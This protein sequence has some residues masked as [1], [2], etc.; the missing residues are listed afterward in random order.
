MSDELY[1]EDGKIVEGAKSPEDIE[2]ELDKVKEEVKAEA[3]ENSKVLANEITTLQDTI[4][5]KEKELDKVGDKDLNFGKLRKQKEEAEKRLTDMKGDLESKI[6]GVEEKINNSKVDN[7]INKLANGDSELADK[8]KYHLNNFKPDEEQDSKKKEENF[9]SRLD[10]A[11]L[12]AN[13]KSNNSLSMDA[14]SSGGDYV[15]LSENKPISEDAKDVA[16]KL[17]LSDKEIGK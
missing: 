4:E 7:E 1:D 12:L 2:I 6:A 9:K 16:R 13:G 8:I 15:P 17:G 11:F 5:E 14:V 10:N 3:E